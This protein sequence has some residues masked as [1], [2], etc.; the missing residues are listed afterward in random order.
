MSNIKYKRTIAAL[1]VLLTATIFEQYWVW[2]LL[3]IFFS[4]HSLFT[5][6]VFLVENIDRDEAPVL[7]W[8]IFTMWFVLGVYYTYYEFWR[9]WPVIEKFL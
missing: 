6:N 2:G 7:F 8:I 4:I 3:F 5:H 1:I 9:S